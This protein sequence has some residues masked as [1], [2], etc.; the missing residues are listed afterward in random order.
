[1]L[2][3]AAHEGLVNNG[4]SVHAGLRSPLRSA[5]DYKVDDHVG[6]HRVEAWELDRIGVDGVIQ[7]SVAKTW[8]SYAG[9][10]VAKQMQCRIVDVVGDNA[11]YLSIDID[12]IGAPTCHRP[13]P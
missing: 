11:C 7:R 3:H 6:F 4:T 5:E 10:S 2:W 9:S 12:V 13:R 1:M 8:T